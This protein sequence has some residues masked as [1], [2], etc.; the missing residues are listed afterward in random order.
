MA[1]CPR[2]ENWVPK[3]KEVWSVSGH[4]NSKGI[5]LVLFVGLFYCPKCKMPFREILYKKKV[6]TV[7]Q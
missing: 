6:S 5:K 4:P 3:P 7:E 1:R 2:C